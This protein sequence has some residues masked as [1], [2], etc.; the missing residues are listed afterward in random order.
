[1]LRVFPKIGTQG[2]FVGEIQKIPV[3]L[4]NEGT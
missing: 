4:T 1:M 3:N 2:M